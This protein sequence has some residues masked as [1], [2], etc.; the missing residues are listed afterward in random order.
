MV[1]A[2][3]VTNTL[4]SGAQPLPL[5]GLTAY[6]F[7]FLMTHI[8]DGGLTAAPRIAITDSGS[9]TN[10]AARYSKNGGA[11]ATATSRQDWTSNATENASNQFEIAYICNIDGEEIL[12]IFNC[13]DESVAGAG[14]DPERREGVGKY[15]DGGSEVQFTNIDIITST[16]NNFATDSNITMIGTD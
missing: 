3:N 12:G 16:S 15:S 7:N 14:N 8:L 6:K 11:D 5:T 10:H 2:K 1:W 13:C 9:G 4:T